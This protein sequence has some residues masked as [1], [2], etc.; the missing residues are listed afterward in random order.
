MTVLASTRTLLQTKPLRRALILAAS[1][2]VAVGLLA[3]GVSGALAAASRAAWGDRFV[4]GN[5]PDVRYTA[6]R[7][8][9]L[10]EYEPDASSCAAAAAAHQSDEVVTYRSALGL[11]GAL[12]L[13][14]WALAR[15]RDRGAALPPTLVPAIG[16]TAFG[17]AAA[18]LS[19]V[20]IDTIVRYGS[21]AGAGQWLG[22]ALVAGTV[23]AWFAA[24][25]ADELAIGAAR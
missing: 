3:V 20:G 23:A 15:R 12:V 9:D 19:L 18:A 25:L 10:R 7:C 13:G 1:M 2:L 14:A 24:K 4:A 21:H 16:V 5:A 6:S 22:G 8:A 17:G 11:I